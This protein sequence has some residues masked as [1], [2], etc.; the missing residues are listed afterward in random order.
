M[1]DG[2]RA[3][4]RSHFRDDLAR[5]LPTQNVPYFGHSWSLDCGGLERIRETDRALFLVCLY[6][7][8]LVDQATHAHFPT[9]YAKFERL[10]RYP[11]F[12]RGLGQFHK[13]PRDILAG[14][15]E[16]GMVAKS[17][18]DDVL[19]ESMNLF[20]EEVVTFFGDHMPEITPSNFFYRLAYDPDVQI[21]ELVVGLDPSLK[22]GIEYKVYRAL[23][24]AIE[25]VG[26]DQ[27]QRSPT[28]VA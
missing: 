21:P 13:N 14:P 26:V 28:V 18:I 17:A 12:C 4:Y 5:F 24:E 3:Y 6:F 8:V 19:R 1:A 15:I 27:G 9:H 20:V 7:T 11:K 2:V 22:D 23:R 10:T 25:S 16:R